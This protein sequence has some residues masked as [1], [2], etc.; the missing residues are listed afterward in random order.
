MG[1]TSSGCLVLWVFLALVCR[2]VSSGNHHFLR[3]QCYSYCLT[4]Y[5]S[6]DTIQAHLEEENKSMVDPLI[7]KCKQSQDCRWCLHICDR[8]DAEYYTNLQHC[9][10]YCQFCLESWCHKD[11]EMQTSNSCGKT[12]GFVHRAAETKAGSCKTVT[13]NKA[14]IPSCV[15]EC[16][17]DSNCGR[18]KKCC[19]HGCSATCEKPMDI[20]I[21]PPKPEKITIKDNEDKGIIVS[22]VQ[23]KNDEG[24]ER[25]DPEFYLLQYWPRSSPVGREQLITS[26]TEYSI[27]LPLH[28][29]QP[30]ASFKFR[31]AAINIHGS[32]GYSNVTVYT[33]LLLEPPKPENLKVERSVYT[34]NKVDL[35][36]TWQPPRL[37]YRLAVKRFLVFWVL[38]P[39]T[40]T[41][42]V[43]QNYSR[44]SVP[45]DVNRFKIPKLEPG[46]QYL[47]TVKALVALNGNQRVG[48]PASL[49]IETYSPPQPV[50]SDNGVTWN[51]AGGNVYNISV[52]ESFYHNGI[53]KASV[54]WK[55]TISAEKYMIYWKA[56]NCQQPSSPSHF[57]EKSA[58][59]HSQEF[60]LYNLQYGCDYVVRIHAVDIKAIMG[61]G[62]VTSFKTPICSEIKIKG[63][64]SHS[65]PNQVSS[66]LEPPHG[67]EVE[68]K[69][70]LCN[71]LSVVVKWRPVPWKEGINYFVQWGASTESSKTQIIY[72][73]QPHKLTLSGNVGKVILY[74]V[75]YATHYTLQLSVISS[76]EKG[77]PVIK[78]F[79]TPQ[80][81]CSH[82]TGSAVTD[83]SVNISTF[84]TNKQL[85]NHVNTDVNKTNTSV[86]HYYTIN[87]FTLYTLMIL[88]YCIV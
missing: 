19:R 56:E 57:Q 71:D 20:D 4:Q 72:T 53:I 85:Y 44:K 14:L 46:T 64:S 43:R 63:H 10:S 82:S 36:I 79:K 34:N 77:R 73:S 26:T 32:R 30:G 51:H 80:Q 66:K 5:T 8:R 12:C 37:P 69:D 35:T 29:F 3:G 49:S 24:R 74:Q 41:S 68:I 15:K 18:N 42:Y 59:S 39:K 17:K 6:S 21:L 50:N 55:S 47:I 81:N 28:S 78:T 83:S 25:I 11:G 86:S 40:S 87:Y 52:L 9:K 23:G 84:I 1:E 13:N 31:V 22:W 2:Q 58:T 62:A 88:I 16:K 75:E 38:I 27:N 60:N 76:Y 70:G 54:T 67:I 7:R 45:A 33:K 65:C 48:R 61:P